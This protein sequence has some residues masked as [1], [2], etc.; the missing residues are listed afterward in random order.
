[1]LV[2]LHNLT[3]LALLISGIFG[4]TTGLV[5]GG[6]LLAFKTT[7]ELYFLWPVAGFFGVKHLLRWFP[8]A[9][10]FHMLYT[11]VSGGFGQFGDYEWKGRIVR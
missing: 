10:P 6:L 9:Q 3:L 5:A 11:V 2:Y 8:V 4:Y 7:V 1:M